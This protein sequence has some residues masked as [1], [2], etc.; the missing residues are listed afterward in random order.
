MRYQLCYV[1]SFILLNLTQS[2]TKEI[3]LQNRTLLNRWRETLRAQSQVWPLARL[4][5]I[6]LDAAFWKGLSL[7]IH[8][9]GPESQAAMLM[10]EQETSASGET[11]M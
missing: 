11:R 3:A 5:T 1:S 9:A 6:R 4:A 7:V 2:P 10:K 8:G